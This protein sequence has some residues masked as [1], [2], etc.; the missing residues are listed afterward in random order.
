MM[1]M[2][3]EEALKEQGLFVST[4]SGNS[5]YPM[6][7]DRKDIVVICPCEGRLS[8]YDVA[9][10][11][12]GDRYILHRIIRALPDSY[13]ICGDNCINREY[14]ITD[15]QIL[16]VLTGFYRDGKE[17]KLNSV[18]YQL[19]IRVW[20]VLYPVRAISRRFRKMASKVKHAVRDDKGEEK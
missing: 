3:I 5:M 7:R 12:V 18:G 6:L 2:K 19:Y 15:K 11:R 13:V 14:G 20:H 16:G 1:Q 4:I 17:I 8:K 9:L 10:Y